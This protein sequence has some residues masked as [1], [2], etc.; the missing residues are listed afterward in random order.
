MAAI[1]DLD[2]V[3]THLNLTSDVDD[4]R[5]ENLI[6]AVE[7]HYLQIRGQ[8]F[9]D[10]GADPPVTVYPTGSDYTA[11]Q[12]INWLIFGGGKLLGVTRERINNYEA[13]YEG[14]VLAKGR[15]MG[16]P[17]SVV[18]TIERKGRYL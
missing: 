3:K 15:V 17:A 10:D 9:D 13:T 11:A 16:Y 4:V 6:P 7:Q 2:G 5:I 8:A 14:G 1:V 18:G 12:M